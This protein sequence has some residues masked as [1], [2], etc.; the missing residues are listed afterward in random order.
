[1]LQ[2][3]S[4]IHS[5]QNERTMVVTWK[6]E[7]IADIMDKVLSGRRLTREDG[8]RLYRSDDLFQIGYM[9]NTVRSRMHGKN[10]Y[11][12]VNR[13]INPTNICVNRC[14]I[15]AFAKSVGEDG[16][17]LLSVDEILNML[18][19]GIHSPPFEVHIVGGLH[20]DIGIDYYTTL[21]RGI[22]E[23]SPDIFVKALTAVEVDHIAKV[24][25]MD[26]ASVLTSL[27]DAGLD[28][29]P[30]GGAE[31]FSRRC[32]MIGWEKKIEG[33]RWLD[34]MR[35]AHSLGIKSNATMLYGHF[36]T[37]EERIDHILKLRS[38]QDDTGG[39][40]AFIPLPF[41]PDNTSFEGMRGCRRCGG[42]D[43]LKT[44]AISRLMLDNFAHI[45]AYWIGLGIK[46]A[47]V[48]LSFGADDLDGTIVDEQIFHAAGARS[49]A[50]M[51]QDELIGF[52]EEAGFSP[53]ERDGAYR[54]LGYV[55]R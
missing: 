1:M 22:K 31:I 26:V 40:Q 49:D 33:D 36:E 54:I 47:Q 29:M 55:K 45:K 4:Y 28:A 10:A 12:V 13:H 15:C 25:G 51:K 39:F 35:I 7:E 16:A 50:G 32:Q 9:A 23:I 14:K 24:S 17:Y 53:L 38:L 18:R 21:I 52:I 8:L 37:N 6:D 44:I 20:P 5:D 48:S 34:V 43:D 46:T 30:G 19:S 11:F 2:E 42:V 3:N 41:M 27:K